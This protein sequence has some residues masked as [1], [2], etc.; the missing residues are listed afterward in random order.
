MR[1]SCQFSLH[2][3]GVTYHSS[4]VSLGAY[5]KNKEHIERYRHYK[6]KEADWTKTPWQLGETSV[7]LI[8][9]RPS[10]FPKIKRM[11]R[12]LNTRQERWAVHLWT[13]CLLLE[14][15]LTLSR[16]CPGRHLPGD[17]WPWR[18][19]TSAPPVFIFATS[20]VLGFASHLREALS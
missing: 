17:G 2:M 15:L 16:Q 18:P 13:Q 6:H 19:S 4:S 12:N 7:S 10:P 1:I 20:H 9:H 14:N 11:N 5:R 8:A 3:C